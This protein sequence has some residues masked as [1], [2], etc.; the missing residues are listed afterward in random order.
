MKTNLI[1]FLKNEYCFYLLIWD[2]QFFTKW[3]EGIWYRWQDGDHE[4][5]VDT[6]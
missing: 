2:S 1:S 3:V 5:Q 4:P 6:S